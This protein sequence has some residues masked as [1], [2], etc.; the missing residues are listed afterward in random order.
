[1]GQDAQIP[2]MVLKIKNETQF[3]DSAVASVNNVNT[4]KVPI[5][6]NRRP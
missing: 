2:T 1:M 3:G 6:T 4:M 5:I